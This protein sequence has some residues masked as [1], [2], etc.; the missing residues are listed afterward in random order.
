MT[1]APL[2]APLQGQAALVAL[3]SHRHLTPKGES[4]LAYGFGSFVAYRV[5]V[6]KHISPT[7]L[8]CSMGSGVA[9]ATFQRSWGTCL[10]ALPCGLLL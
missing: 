9:A 1:H 2:W 5:A 6:G 4:G 3:G 10:S 8:C 7:P